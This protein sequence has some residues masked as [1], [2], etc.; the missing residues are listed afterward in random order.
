MTI[1]EERKRGKYDRYKITHIDGSPTDPDADYF[2]LRLDDGGSDPAHIEACRRAILMYA[3]EIEE[4]L[5][6]LAADI[7]RQYGS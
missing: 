7:Q 3:I 2:V 1:K 5:P 4:H 6:M